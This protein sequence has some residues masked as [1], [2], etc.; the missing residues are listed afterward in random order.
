MWYDFDK[1]YPFKMASFTAVTLSV[2]SRT[3][4]TQFQLS[5][6]TRALKNLPDLTHDDIML[7]REFGRIYSVRTLELQLKSY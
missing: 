6:K 3:V 7:C 1:K 5:M 4:L 2:G